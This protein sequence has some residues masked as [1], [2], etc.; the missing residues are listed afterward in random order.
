M[1]QGAVER[2]PGDY[3]DAELQTFELLKT[4]VLSS[5]QAAVKASNIKTHSF[6]ARV[7]ERDSF[8]IK[9]EDGN[10]EDPIE[11]VK[12]VVGARVVCL[13]ASDLP[14]LGEVVGQTFKVES[15]VDKAT[16]TPPDSFGYMS[17]HY[18]CTL[19]PAYA[20]RRVSRLHGLKF[21]IQ[22]RTILQDAWANVSHHLSYKGKAGIPDFLERDF[23]ALSGLF[24]IADKHFELFFD[25]SKKSK[26]AAIEE[27]KGSDEVSK[28]S[29]IPINADTIQAY[30]EAHYLDRDHIPA[31][32]SK[33]ADELVNAGYRSIQEVDVDLVR[34]SDA[35]IA[36]EKTYRP[37]RHGKPPM[38]PD[39]GF[40]S[41]GIARMALSI[42]NPK[43]RKD[44]K[45]ESQ[46]R[47][48]SFEHLLK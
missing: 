28:L 22:C 48:I 24:Y 44:D 11:E 40:A 4:E 7:K 9:I 39:K 5:L 21:E 13:F 34:A 18:I 8:L 1:T 12:D 30:L 32:A 14:K 20:G 10:Y 35:A 23:N 27:L 46:E 16:E 31:Q 3:Y 43:Y 2:L 36:F 42:A 6:S 29:L 26:I 41:V 17:V 47:F 15:K 45:R 25:E 33:F 38:R 19:D 37:L